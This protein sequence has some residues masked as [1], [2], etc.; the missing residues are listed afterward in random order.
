MVFKF[1]AFYKYTLL[2]YEKRLNEA[3][4]KTGVPEVAAAKLHQIIQR[5]SL[6][7]AC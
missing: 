5:N 1:Y 6:D 4:K 2:L 3:G 7:L